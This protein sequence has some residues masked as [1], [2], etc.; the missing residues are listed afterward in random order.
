M[1]DVSLATLVLLL[2]YWGL[3]MHFELHILGMS[4]GRIGRKKTSR[5]AARQGF[6][7][8]LIG[9]E[10]VASRHCSRGISN[11]RFGRCERLGGSDEQVEDTA[12]EKVER[13]GEQIRRKSRTPRSKSVV[14]RVLPF[15]RMLK[16]K[17]HKRSW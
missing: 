13:P 10:D 7:S 14:M 11:S 2:R 15:E 1:L 5:Y 8:L 6:L 17:T 16:V 3:S 9:K 12:V 4:V